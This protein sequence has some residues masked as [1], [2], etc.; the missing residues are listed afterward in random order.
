MTIVNTKEAVSVGN[1]LFITVLCQPLT[2]HQCQRTVCISLKLD[3]HYLNIGVYASVHHELN[4]ADVAC[5]TAVGGRRLYQYIVD[6]FLFLFKLLKDSF[7]LQ[8][9]K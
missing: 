9:F 8:V 3:L 2:D 6:D 5:I 7:Y 4:T 1:A